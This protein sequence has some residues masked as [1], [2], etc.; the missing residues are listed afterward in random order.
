MESGSRLGGAEFWAEKGSR[1][2]VERASAHVFVG[3]SEV[4]HIRDQG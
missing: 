4:Q 3:G 1:F 2:R